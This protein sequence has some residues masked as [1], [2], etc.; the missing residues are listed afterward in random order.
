MEKA[1]VIVHL[2]KPIDNRELD[3]PFWIY[4][5]LKSV[6]RSCKEM[7]QLTNASNWANDVMHYRYPDY[8][9]LYSKLKELY[10]EQAHNIRH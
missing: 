4:E 9:E 10:W 3:S 7:R 1:K 2:I 6:I 8:H 5:K